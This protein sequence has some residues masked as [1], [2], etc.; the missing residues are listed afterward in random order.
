LEEFASAIRPWTYEPAVLDGRPV[1]FCVTV[2]VL[3]HVR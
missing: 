3:L 2:S 1:P